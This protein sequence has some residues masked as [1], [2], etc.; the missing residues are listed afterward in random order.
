MKNSIWLVTMMVMVVFSPV[1]TMADAAMEA[2]Q[3]QETVVEGTIAGI[4]N[5]IVTIS[6]KAADETVSEVV[7]ETTSETKY[8]EGKALVDLK[9]GDSVTVAYEVKDGKN[10]ALSIEKNVEETTSQ[11]KAEVVE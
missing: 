8:D 1:V 9:A 6:I 2:M 3:A 5:G 4:D 11:M 7:V 10:V